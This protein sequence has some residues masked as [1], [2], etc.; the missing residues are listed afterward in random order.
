ML[1]DDDGL[2]AGPLCPVCDSE[3][4]REPLVTES[5]ITLVYVCPEHGLAF[6]VDPYGD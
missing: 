5:A 6:A 2:P 1:P 4:A 3:L